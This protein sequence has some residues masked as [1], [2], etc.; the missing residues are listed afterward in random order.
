[1]LFR[2]KRRGAENR[3]LFA[4]HCSHKRG[5]QRDFGFPEP[6]VPAHQPVH[7]FGGEHVP[8]HGVN[9]SSLIR[10]FLKGKTLAEGFIVF[11]VLFKGKAFS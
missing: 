9:G 4:V 11:G 3:N 7:G 8:D 10:G 6:H 2:Q 1:M 5:A